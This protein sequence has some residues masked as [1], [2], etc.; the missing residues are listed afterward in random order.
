M[1]FA[2]SGMS[3]GGCVSSV[4]KALGAVPGAHVDD[5]TVGSATVS[6]DASRTNPAAISQAVRDAGYEPVNPGARATAG[7]T[8]GGGGGRKGGSC[9]G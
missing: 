7:A 9:C 5:V 4:R 2:I 3:C 1:T 8:S 6:Y